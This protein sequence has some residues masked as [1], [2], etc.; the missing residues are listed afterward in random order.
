MV[1]LHHIVGALLAGIVVAGAAQAA[2]GTLNFSST[3]NSSPPSVQGAFQGTAAGLGAITVGKGAL[4]GSTQGGSGS[5]SFQGS[6]PGGDGGS[7][8]FGSTLTPPS[9]PAPP[10]LPSPPTVPGLPSLP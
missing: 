1:Q 6:L 7:A 5:G 10:A 3:L 4:T 9:L 8:S 2:G